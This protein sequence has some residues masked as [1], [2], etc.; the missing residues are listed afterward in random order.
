MQ[1]VIHQAQI[2]QGEKLQ[3]HGELLKQV[4]GMMQQALPT[5]GEGDRRYRGLQ[6]NLYHLQLRTGSLLPNLE[7]QPGIVRRVG[8]FAA[9]GSSE[10]D[11]WEGMYL[12]EEKVAIKM[13]RPVAKSE[14]NFQVCVFLTD[15][16]E[17]RLKRALLAIHERN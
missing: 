1:T 17:K 8:R 9:G 10:T 5:F 2:A 3:E 7:L 12:D 16:S 15:E 6:R 11:I 4:M 14:R 13:I